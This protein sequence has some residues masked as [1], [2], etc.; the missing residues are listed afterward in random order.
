MKSFIVSA[1][2]IAAL[3]V[4]GLLVAPADA[5]P[6]GQLQ[7][8]CFQSQQIVYQQQLVAQPV[9]VAPVVAQYYQPPVQQ[10]VA[11]QVQSYSTYVQPVRQLQVQQ[12]RGHKHHRQQV[13]ALNVREPRR[14]VSKQIN[15][16]RG[17]RRAAV[18]APVAL[19]APGY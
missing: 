14:Q 17:G 18:V 19:V 1:V 2:A 15:I 6:V 7:G 5:C 4:L 16:N 12:L 8:D 10:F 3:C 11:P 9:V 13:L